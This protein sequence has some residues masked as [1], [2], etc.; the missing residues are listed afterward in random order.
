MY[1][2]PYCSIILGKP[3]YVDTKVNIDNKEETISL[4]FPQEKV[5]FELDHF[6]KLAYEKKTEIKEEK[7]L[8]NWL[9]FT[10]IL[11]KMN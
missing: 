1:I 6:K 2:D 4:R 10:L 7:L 5:K 8:Q 3:Y 11:C 9:Q